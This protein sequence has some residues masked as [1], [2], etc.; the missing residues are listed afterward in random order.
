MDAYA[1]S[2]QGNLAAVFS[3]AREYPRLRFWA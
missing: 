3:L 1:T 2:K